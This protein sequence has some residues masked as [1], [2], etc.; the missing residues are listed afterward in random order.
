MKHGSYK[1]NINSLIWA[2]YSW[3]KSLYLLVVFPNFC[4]DTYCLNRIE[5][6]SSKNPFETC[7]D[8]VGVLIVP[9]AQEFDLGNQ[10]VSPGDGSSSHLSLK[11]LPLSCKPQTPAN[12]DVYS[13]H[14]CFIQLQPYCGSLW[15]SF[16]SQASL[17]HV[18]RKMG[19]F[20][21]DCETYPSSNL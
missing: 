5:S 6:Q 9:S 8:S 16:S 3:N 19:H 13:I 21:P 18:G 1:H 20:S 14:L 7:L 4:P 12:L 2:F 17:T 11:L 10:T 15:L